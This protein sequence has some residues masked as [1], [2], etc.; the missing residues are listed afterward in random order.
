M[1]GIRPIPTTYTQVLPYLIQKGLVEIKPLSPP[2]NLLP[3]DYDA[4]VGCDFHAGS[5]G[6]TTEKCLELK[7]KVQDLLDLKIISFTPEGPNVKGSSNPGHG[8][9]TINT[10]EGLDN[11]VLT[12]MVDQVKTPVSKIHEKL[13][14]Y[15]AFEELHANCKICLVNPDLCERMNKCLQQMMDK[16]LIQIG[17][18]IK[19]EYVSFIESQGHTPFEIPYRQV[20]TPTPFQMPSQTSVQISV[21]IMSKIPFQIPVKTEDPI[22]LHVPAPFPIESTKCRIREK[23]PTG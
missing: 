13:N 19:L 6:H 20:E 14:G 15:K 23:Q 22:I 10:V 21:P 1:E 9:P 7:F 12:Q 18:T 11:T 3:R 16:G 17:Y 5:P 4:N 2:P 8:G